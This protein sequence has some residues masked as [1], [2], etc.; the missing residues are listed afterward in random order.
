MKSVLKWLGILACIFIII[1]VAA[2]IILP[3]VI[4]VQKYKPVIEQKVVEATGRKF[5][6][7]DEINFS[8]FPWVGV[9]VTDV[10]FGNP[11]GYGEEFMISVKNFEVRLKVIPLL[12]KK[13]EIKTFVLESPE[14]YLEK[15]KTG[16]TNWQGIGKKQEQIKEEKVT[17][18]SPNQEG[19]GLPIEGLLVNSFLITNGQLIYIDQGTKT[20][21]KIS[22]L[23]LNLTDISLEKPVALIFSAQIDGNPVSLDGTIGPI[24]KEPGKGV[25]TLD[26]VLKALG[27]LEVKLDGSIIDPMENQRFDLNVAMASFSP[28]KLVT[29]LKLEFP[30]Q[31]NDPKVFNEISFKT[32]IKGNPNN[33]TM[34]NGEIILDDSKL[35]FSAKVKEFDRPN[36][37]FDL[38]LDKMDLDRYL[39]PPPPKEAT[40][41]SDIKPT[42]KTEP[43]IVKKAQTDYG[44]LRKLMLDG[45]IKV[46]KIKAHGANIENINAH[47]LAKK[48]KITINPL[49]MDLYDGSIASKLELNVQKSNPATKLTLDANGIKVGPLLKDVMQMEVIE[50][51][52]KT[53]I[54]LS[55]KG[56]TP[57]MIKKTLNG[58]GE[59]I[60]IDGAIIGIDLSNLVQNT[61]A[62]L[63]MA[64]ESKEK[65]RTDFAEFKIPFTSKDGLVNIDGTRLVSPVLRILVKGD[66]NLVREKLDLRIDPKF[67]ATLKGQGDKEERTGIAVPV[68]IKG[69]FTSPKI[70]PDLKGVLGDEKEI[71]ELKKQV[72]GTE[73]EREKA[74]DS[75]KEDP[76]K[77]LENLLPGL[78]D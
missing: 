23:N 36:L 49:T 71:E 70:R 64:E 3:K 60:F 17:Q 22:D 63:G 35:L 11:D 65:P 42:E 44:P 58:K 72:L 9:K 21:N 29:A 75:L 1:I 4:D 78:I 26:L 24:G 5:T 45:K 59:L 67:V 41:E 73:E 10:R 55:M 7:G 2:I 52:L 19:Q 13:I 77:Q 6:L 43:A 30:I 25:I 32:N 56:E 27:E 69:T 28:R 34:S 16:E 47:I 12:S 74:I 39:P 40:T 18:S 15:L 68:T 57:E 46:N 31:T 20:K 38:L 50:G 48:G 8:V 33:I 76:A 51:A 37:E 54:G 14:I 53:N 66:I 62:K 61:K